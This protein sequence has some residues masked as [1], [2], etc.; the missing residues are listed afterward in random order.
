MPD[1]NGMA[2]FA[3]VVRSQG[4]SQAA[5]DTGLPKSTISRKV[6][7][8]EEQL[9]VRLLQRD[10]RNL[11]LTQVGALFYQHCESIVNEVEAAKAV[12]EHTQN[13]VSG[14]LRIAIPV[15]FSQELIA[16][17]CSGFMRL[18]PNVQLDVQFTDSDVGL[19]GEGFDVAIKY[20]PLQSSDLVAR[21]LFERQPILV[22]SPGYLKT[23]GIPATPA[24]LGDHSGILLGTSRSAPIWPLGKGSRKT[25]VSFN[26]KVRVNSSIMVKQ[27]ALD[28]FGIA[29][30]SHSVCKKELA[31]G[32]LVPI[33]PEWPMEPFKVYG[34]Y[35]SRRQ[36]ATNISVFLDFFAKR[37]GSQESLLGMMG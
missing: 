21:L 26:R 37:I 20:G 13:D 30:L 7:Q 23:K 8:L 28:D 19:V 15:S 9:G 12:I 10:T 17:L 34:V 5:R 31:S 18:Y 1:L 22:A 2:L 29:M 4:F 6:A 11:S 24:E 14:S 3:A 25:M 36:L 35:S 32:A 33:L 16:K 27:L